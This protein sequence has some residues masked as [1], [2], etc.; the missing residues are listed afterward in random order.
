MVYE[1]AKNLKPENI[2]E[3]LPSWMHGLPG[4]TCQPHSAY[5]KL[6]LPGKRCPPLAV[7]LLETVVFKGAEPGAYLYTNQNGIVSTN[8]GD[9]LPMEARRQLQKLFIDISEQQPPLKGHAAPLPTAASMFI[10]G[11]NGVTRQAVTPKE[12]GQAMRGQAS[13]CQ[14]LQRV[15]TALH[16]SSVYRNTY[17]LEQGAVHAK[18]YTNV[19][20]N[21]LPGIGRKGKP[22][23]L[24][25]RCPTIL[26]CQL[27]KKTP[28]FCT[29]RCFL[30][31]EN[32][33]FRGRLQRG[34]VPR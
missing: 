25:L 29:P 10:P 8:Q 6:L 17:E 23:L 31:S 9:E 19:V 26:A 20:S 28:S 11:G 12:L 18:Q 5:F 4:V 2:Q 14:A 34:E 27:R 22:P 30:D 1:Q 13:G 24:L 3:S 32:V 15:V 16:S 21:T 7:N 33:R